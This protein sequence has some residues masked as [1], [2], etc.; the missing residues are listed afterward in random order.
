[1]SSMKSDKTNNRADL[2]AYPNQ[3][4]VY[5]WIIVIVLLGVAIA[6]AVG[7]SP[8]LMWPTTLTLLILPVRTFLAW[9]DRE[10][11]KRQDLQATADFTTN[12]VLPR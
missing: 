5:F 12:G 1:M 3:T 7:P 8:I 11:K 2:R 6:G 10:I 9:P 4:A